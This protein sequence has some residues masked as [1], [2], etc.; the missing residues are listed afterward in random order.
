VTYAVINCDSLAQEEKYIPHQTEYGRRG[1]RMIQSR[2]L[3]PCSTNC[4]K[5][6]HSRSLITGNL[7]RQNFAERAQHATDL[8]NSSTAQNN[9]ESLKYNR[10]FYQPNIVTLSHG[11]IPSHVCRTVT[12]DP[13][14]TF[15]FGHTS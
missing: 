6:H 15:F 4:G 7:H 8:F 13:V 11:W 14:T 5:L 12:P 1:A 10:T 9:K 3:F 2:H